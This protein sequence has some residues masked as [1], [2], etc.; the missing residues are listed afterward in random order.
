MEVEAVFEAF[1]NM[2]YRVG[3]VMLKSRHDAEDAVQDTLIKYME[4]H[5]DFQDREHIK[6]WLLPLQLLSQRG[7]E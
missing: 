2:L 3:V 7:E 5:K 1:G 6:A 4:H